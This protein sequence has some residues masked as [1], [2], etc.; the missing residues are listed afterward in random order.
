MAAAVDAV[1]AA[2]V[3]FPGFVVAAVV[4]VAVVLISVSSVVVVLVVVVAELVAVTVAWTIGLVAIVAVAAAVEF[5][6]AESVAVDMTVDV[7]VDVD[8]VEVGDR[9]QPFPF[10]LPSPRAETASSNNPPPSLVSPPPQLPRRK[11]P[12][13]SAA[14]VRRIDW[15]SSVKAKTRPLWTLW[16]AGVVEVE[17]EGVGAGE[18]TLPRWPPAA[19][20]FSFP[21]FVSHSLARRFPPSSCAFSAAAFVPGSVAQDSVDADLFHHFHR[22][23]FAASKSTSVAAISFASVPPTPVASP[24]QLGASA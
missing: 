16:T 23:P 1:V 6:V 10:P 21:V 19:K 22:F 20:R 11:P 8:G 7:A 24:F 14:G 13:C 4:A 12:A 9:V 3:D 5:V 15:W 17:V 18:A 2:V